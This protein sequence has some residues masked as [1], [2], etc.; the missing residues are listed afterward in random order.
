LETAIIFGGTQGI[1]HIIAEYFVKKNISIS[2]CARNIDDMIN[3]N[4]INFIKCNVGNGIEV[5]SSF[6]DHINKFG[7]T[8][9]F[10]INA[11]GVQGELGY[12]WTISEADF[13]NTIKTNLTGCFNVAKVAI[14]NL[15]LYKKSGS[16]IMFSGGGSCYARPNFISYGVSKT[17][18]LRLVETISEELKISGNEKI[19]INAIAPGSVNTKMTKEVIESKDRVGIKAYNEACETV[20]NGGTKLDEITNLVE[21]LCDFEKN[22]YISGRLIHVRENYN[23]F[24]ESELFK[25]EENGKLRRINL[26]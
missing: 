9:D 8:P 14:E 3:I 26:I 20:K 18:V 10:I 16:I 7:T 2:I 15:L 12:S 23:G 5:K 17:G 11:A 13:E 24:V 6:E 25:K 22:R 4:K 19:I 21:F 1:G